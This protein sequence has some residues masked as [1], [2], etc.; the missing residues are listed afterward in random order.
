MQS[1]N[2]AIVA[3]M[4]FSLHLVL[5]DRR[6]H[7]PF[8]SDC[9]WHPP[10]TIIYMHALCLLNL[11]FFLSRCRVS[12]HSVL[13]PYCTVHGR[14]ASTTCSLMNDD[15]HEEPA[16][17]PIVLPVSWSSAV[18]PMSWSSAV[19]PEP[20]RS[21]SG[22]RLAAAR[23]RQAAAH[24]RLAACSGVEDPAYSA[25]V[26]QCIASVFQQ[27]RADVR[28][29][30]RAN[31]RD[32]GRPEKREVD[33]D[34]FGD[35]SSNDPEEIALFR[36][37]LA[38]T[39]SVRDAIAM[40]RTRSRS[41]RRVPAEDGDSIATAQCPRCRTT[42]TWNIHLRARPKFCTQC[43]TSFDPTNVPA[44]PRI[45]CVSCGH[46]NPG[47]A[48]FCMSCGSKCRLATASGDNIPCEP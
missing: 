17:R 25:D 29:T 20:E 26:R 15:G 30:V 48:N 33:E 22:A 43:G 23:Q 35:D 36:E 9:R 37:S 28:K 19:A 40:S 16:S 42:T 46:W 44:I 34:D 38:A 31:R 2:R 32:Q 7:A 8:E 1:S 18:A 24:A 3:D 39:K 10:C 6:L 27:M 4:S 5:S 47:T 13:Q 12:R 41:P 45:N 14:I 11:F 21:G